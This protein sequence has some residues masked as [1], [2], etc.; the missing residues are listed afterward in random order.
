MPRDDLSIDFVKKMAPSAEAQDPAAVLEDFIHRTANLPE[1][2]RFIQDEIADKDRT[3]N[4]CLK[5]IEENDA[6][7]QRWIRQNGSH[8]PLPRE[9]ALREIIRENYAKADKLSEEKIAL[10][11]KAQALLDKHLRHLDLQIKALGDRGEPG[12][13]DPD[14]IPSVVRPS[15]ANNSNTSLRVLGVTTSHTTPLNPISN[16][17]A[18][19]GPR[20][21]NPQIRTT[22]S[23]AHISS[24][25]PTSPAASMIM[26][27]RNQRES[28]A[29]PGSGAP[30]RGPRISSGLGSL[31]TASSGLARHSSLGPGTPK[32]GTPVASARAGSA[33]PRGTSK[34]VGNG[35]GRKGTPS[36]GV[37]RKKPPNSKSTLSRVKRAGVSK[38]SPAST[39][40]SELSDAE[41]VRSSR[42]GSRAGSGTPVPRPHHHHH[43]KR[44]HPD[45]DMPDRGSASAGSGISDDEEDEEGKK[46]CLC[47][48]VS[49]GD[50]V[51]CD[52]P[53]CPYEWFH[54][55]CVGLKSEPE[56]RWYCPSCTE[57]MKKKGK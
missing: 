56:G 44:A 25:A 28:S 47:Q 30:K 2:I 37:G 51:A 7:I 14:E 55:T 46:Y 13:T 27:N 40:D 20:A 45:E 8:A 57:T 33:G 54:W 4:E 29:G 21:S 17:A 42:A 22:Q 16:N 49:Y 38:G 53:A 19:G 10:A 26:S 34:T 50:M 18:T 36:A 31:P 41:S 1:E 23:Q 12:F 32:A 15:A 3:F 52:N 43:R 9:Q 24:S 39:A 35:T 5:T 6:K 48:H 11:A